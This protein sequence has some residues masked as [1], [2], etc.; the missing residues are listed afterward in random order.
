MARRSAV[1]GR[2]SFPALHAPTC[3]RWCA[4]S[5]AHAACRTRVNPGIQSGPS[6]VAVDPPSFGLLRAEQNQEGANL[7]LPCRAACSQGRA[8]WEGLAEDP[9]HVLTPITPTNRVN[10][11]GTR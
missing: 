5:K 8:G 6:A 3:S 9:P 7:A 1:N 4:A 2:R 11:P 10:A